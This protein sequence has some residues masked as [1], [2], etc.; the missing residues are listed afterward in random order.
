MAPPS[1]G[2]S[3]ARP[4]QS[5]QGMR[6]EPYGNTKE[7]RELRLEY[8]K[9]LEEQKGMLILVVTIGPMLI[10]LVQMHARTSPIFVLNA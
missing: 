4:S 2:A 10:C 3:Q 6:Y 5:T 7:K 1:I 8:R 9:L